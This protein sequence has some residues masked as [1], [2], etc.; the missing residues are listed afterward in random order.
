MVARGIGGTDL[1]LRV[2]I[3]SQLSSRDLAALQGQWEQVEWEED[4]VLNPPDNL[5]PPGVLTTFRGNHFT[6]CSAEGVLLLEGTCT[7]DASVV[8]KAIE[9]VD[10]MGPDRGK[11]LKGIYKLEGNTFSF[12]AADEGMPRPTEFKT[13]RGQTKRVFVRHIP[14]N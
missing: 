3:M 5:S 4:G 6:V 14:S 13:G 10:A 9:Y 11:V 1:S 8:P 7:L 12:I 2:W